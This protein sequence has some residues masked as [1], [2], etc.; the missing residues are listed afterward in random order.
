M[1]PAFLSRCIMRKTNKILILILLLFLGF[2]LVWLSFL[3]VGFIPVGIGLS[4]SDWLAFLGNYLAMF[5]TVI[6]GYVAYRQ[7]IELNHINEELMAL[8]KSDLSPLIRIISFSG[9]ADYNPQLSESII[10]DKILLFPIFENND[11]A[12]TLGFAA[13]HFLNKNEPD[14][15]AITYKIHFKFIGKSPA[16]KVKLK[17]ISFKKDST[18]EDLLNINISDFVQ[19]SLFNGTEFFFILRVIDTSNPKDNSSIL[20]ELL[21][22]RYM[23]IL[24]E[25]SSEDYGVYEEKISIRKMYFEDE[26]GLIDSNYIHKDLI[27]SEEYSVRNIP[28]G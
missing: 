4:K 20:Y 17:Y 12:P 21:R 27:G 15:C 18:S 16:H 23:N 19:K 26:D 14:S 28:N 13:V 1:T 6:L 24:F 2:I 8:Q 9:E 11:V 7:N 25:L 22:T 5:G 3:G 10:A